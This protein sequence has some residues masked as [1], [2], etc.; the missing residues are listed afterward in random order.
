MI[1]LN[2]KKVLLASMAVMA[3]FESTA[4]LSVNIALTPEQMVQNLVGSGVQISNVSVTACDST[5][6]YYQSVG[7]ELG[8]SQG[9]LLTTGKALYAIG[10]NNSI[11]N[12]STSA[13]TCDFFDNDCPGSTLLNQAQ[14]RTTYDATQFEFDIVPQ[15][16]SIKFKYTFASEEYNE[17]VNSQFN[18]VFGFYISGPGIGTDVN[19]ALIPTTGQV[20][21]INT[22]NALSNQAFYYNNQ[23]PLGQFIQYD[24]FTRNLVAKVGNLIPCE[25][26]H[27]KLVIADGTDR[28]YDSGVFIQAIESNPVLVTTATSNGLEYMVEGCSDGSITFTRQI[29]TNEPQDV[30]YFVG[31][32]ATNGVDY[33]PAIG[34]GVP[35]TANTIFIP[36]N[37]ASVTINIS[38]VSD[39]FPEGEEY[40]TIFLANPLCS[41]NEVVDSINF[42][43]NDDIPLTLE[44]SETNTCIGSCVTLTATV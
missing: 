11:G 9:L 15:G 32:T 3:I 42:Y 33:T 37:E 17:W 16:D 7:T 10:P 39:I 23:N 20:V 25:T 6:G 1:K 29:V 27:L 13:G 5:Y 8:T 41:D 43:I 18:D 35:L 14:D 26:Y 22:V 24:G 30:V 34:S 40:I 44:A 12:C 28:V 21:A 19:I 36:A 4:Q 2:L 38:A 31:G